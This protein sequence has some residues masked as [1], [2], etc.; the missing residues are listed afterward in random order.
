VILVKNLPA[1]TS[2]EELRELFSKHGKLG[3]LV[4]PP[5]GVT[6]IIEFG[7]PSEAKTAF[8]KLAYT[9]FKHLPLYLEWAPE[10][11]FTSKVAIVSKEKKEKKS[12]KGIICCTIA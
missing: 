3:R 8:T 1:G 10:E 11:T 12:E 7:D 4:L 2:S 9:K 6:A 5:T